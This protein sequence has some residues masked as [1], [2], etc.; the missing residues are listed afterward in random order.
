M[1]FKV[2]VVLFFGT[3]SSVLIKYARVNITANEPTIAYASNESNST[4][5]PGKQQHDVICLFYCVLCN[6]I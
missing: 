6:L 5:W 2:I 4:V 1:T 3:E